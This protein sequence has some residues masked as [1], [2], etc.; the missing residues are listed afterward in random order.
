MIKKVQ[1]KVYDFPYGV[2]NVSIIYDKYLYSLAN[3]Y[4]I[5]LIY[6]GCIIITE[7]FFTFVYNKN[8]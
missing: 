4:K 8:I 2:F 3:D 7:I 5:S 1:F 6:V